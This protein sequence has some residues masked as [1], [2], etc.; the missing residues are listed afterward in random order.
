MA[1]R[2]RGMK[3]EFDPSSVSNPDGVELYESYRAMAIANGVDPRDARIAP[4][5]ADDEEWFTV[6][7][8]VREQGL[9]EPI[10]GEDLIRRARDED[11]DEMMKR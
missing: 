8:R 7:E 5:R 9:T 4:C 3:N 11:H 6:A 10:T 1:L 2:I